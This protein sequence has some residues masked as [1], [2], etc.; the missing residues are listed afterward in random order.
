MAIK[1]YHFKL[2]KVSER[3]QNLLKALYS[4]LP[5]TGV[6]ERFDRGIRDAISR[7]VGDKCRFRLEAVHEDTYSQFIDKLP[8]PSLLV[9]FGMAPLAGKAILEIDFTLAMMLVERMLGGES[10]S[11]PDVR[12]LSDTEQGVLQYLILQVLEGVHTSCGKDERVLFRFE[13]F[14][15]HA[16]EV[17][18][19]VSGNEGM[20]TLVYRLN[21]GRRSG[22]IRLS[23]PD[24]FVEEAFLNVEA[25]NEIRSEERG[26]M[27]RNLRRFRS[28][29]FPL[30]AEAGRVSLTGSEIA[31]LEEGDI[32]IFDQS[33][34]SLVD[35]KPSGQTLLR[36]GDGRNGGFDAELFGDQKSSKLKILGVHK[37]D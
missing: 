36:V 30:W 32:I 1:P 6:R 24:P 20:V 8:E 13:R 26:Y 12:E 21:I 35:G 3:R 16:H 27:T 28:I 22:F 14:A 15:F 34:V 2:K 5:A 31:Q 4:Y 29:S 18:E 17:E 23:L 11:V 25:P 9:V 7:H 10:G 37:G 19:L 33:S